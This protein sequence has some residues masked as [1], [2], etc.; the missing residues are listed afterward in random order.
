MFPIIG[1]PIPS[2]F[3][4]Q[5]SWTCTYLLMPYFQCH[6]HIAISSWTCQREPFFFKTASA[7]VAQVTFFC[8]Y[9]LL[10]S[11]M[12]ECHFAIWYASLW[13]VPLFFKTARGESL[14]SKIK[15]NY[16]HYCHKSCCHCHIAIDQIFIWRGPLFFKTAR[17]ESLSSTSQAASMMSRV[18]GNKYKSCLRTNIDHKYLRKTIWKNNLTS[19]SRYDLNTG[20]DLFLMFSNMRGQCELAKLLAIQKLNQN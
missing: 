14:S 6:C 12:H 2:N 10:W 13:R 19:S 3:F 16:C 18:Q 17:G 1:A 4:L 20:R 11:F 9:K 5:P 8:F 15:I 7:L